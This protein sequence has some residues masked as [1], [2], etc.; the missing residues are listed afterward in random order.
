MFPT[1]KNLNMPKISKE[2]LSFWAISSSIS[3]DSNFAI[4]KI[5]DASLNIDEGTYASRR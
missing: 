3:V 2:V 1:Y 4:P 5:F